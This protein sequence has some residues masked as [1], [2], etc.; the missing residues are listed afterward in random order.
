MKSFAQQISILVWA[1]YF[2]LSVSG[3]NLQQLYC[4][5][6]DKAYVSLFEIEN[7]CSEHHRKVVEVKSSCC[8]KLLN[9]NSCHTAASD[10]QDSKDCC[11]SKSN[12]VKADIDVLYSST[13][14]L[15][16]V[17]SKTVIAVPVLKSFI[18]TKPLRTDTT[19]FYH[20]PPPKRHGKDLRDFV[21]SY[22]C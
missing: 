9:K 19:P 18:F 16:P 11:D 14:P 21:Q 7:D 12:L 6:T 22:L 17:I 20:P 1:I 2:G 15:L 5:C 10:N 3:I 13:I 8:K 4:H